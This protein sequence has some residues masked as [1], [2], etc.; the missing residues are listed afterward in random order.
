MDDNKNNRCN[1]RKK[2][3]IMHSL[4]IC[5]MI[6]MI[7]LLSLESKQFTFKTQVS[8]GVPLP[9]QEG[10]FTSESRLTFHLIDFWCIY[11]ELYIY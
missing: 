3:K 7:I 8:A 5:I 4:L 1:V 2:R 11:V 9:I 10:G 6:I